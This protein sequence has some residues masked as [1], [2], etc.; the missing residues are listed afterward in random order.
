MSVSREANQQCLDKETWLLFRAS[1][2]PTQMSSRK[3]HRGMYGDGVYFASQACKSHRYT[4]WN[5][6][7]N[8]ACNCHRTWLDPVSRCLNRSTQA[9]LLFPKWLAMLQGRALQSQMAMLAELSPRHRW[10]G[11]FTICKAS[12]AVS[13]SGLRLLSMSSCGRSP[14]RHFL[15][16]IGIGKRDDDGKLRCSIVF[17]YLW[18]LLFYHCS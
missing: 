14:Y 15:K 1:S 10:R 18:F 3:C 11:C 16:G 12:L 9:H 4:C 13:C 5:S 2:T 17:L 6:K 8:K 7:C